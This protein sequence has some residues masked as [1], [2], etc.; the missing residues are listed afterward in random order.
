M[1]EDAEVGSG[2][3]STTR[4]VK[5]LSA[6]VDMARDAEVGEGNGGD[7]KTVKD[8][9]PKSQADLQDILLHYALEKDKF[10]LIVFAMVKALSF[11][12]TT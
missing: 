1:A 2:T 9:L 4:S 12:V 8:H 10:P 11:K 3:S 6:S 7:N 5:N